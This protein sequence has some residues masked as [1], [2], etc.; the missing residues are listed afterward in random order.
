[1]RNRFWT[2]LVAALVVL[3]ACSPSATPPPTS[4]A[5]PSLTPPSGGEPSASAPLSAVKEGGT[6]VVALS[7]DIAS[8]DP[9]LSDDTNVFYVANQTVQGLLGLEPGTISRC[10]PCSG[11]RPSDSVRRWPDVYVHPP[12]RDQVP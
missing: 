2:Q 9:A 8:A 1:M 11:G 7:G 3:S 4:G 6:L 10:R 5:S 12:D